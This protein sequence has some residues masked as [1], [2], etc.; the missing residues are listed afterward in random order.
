MRNLIL[1][2]LIVTFVLISGCSSDDSEI[3]QEELN[4]SLVALTSEEIADLSFLREEEKLARDVYLY[5]YGLY[6]NQLFKNISNSEQTHMDSVLVLL[7][8]YNLEDP[9]SNVVGVF[10]NSELQEIYNSLIQQSTISELEALIV[11]NIIEDLDIKD[12]ILNE[13]RT[14]KTDLLTVYGSLKCGSRN[15]LRSYYAQLVQ[16]EGTYTPAYISVSDFEDIV[17]T[18][19]EKCNNN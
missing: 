17:S 8:K 18:S 16:K 10:N 9:I 2:S 15:H 13:G 14:T 6:G 7:N 19:N 11:G 3:N 1:Y 5:S 4:E 12:L